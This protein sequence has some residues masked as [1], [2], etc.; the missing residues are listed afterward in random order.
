MRNDDQIISPRQILEK[1]QPNQ[2]AE[3]LL[4]R[5]L[6]NNSTK[7]YRQYSNTNPP[8]V[9]ASVMNTLYDMGIRHFMIDTPSVDKE[10]DEGILAA[11]HQFWNYP[12][13]P[14]KD[15]TITEL[16]YVPPS[17][18]DGFYMMNLQIASFENDASPS[19]P[20]LYKF[21]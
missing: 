20:T 14:R 21:I 9:E 10:L 3:A 5:T 19:K 4:I 1:F 7:K 18:S 8:Y 13:N 12:K 17:I 11:H 6:P 16:I 2:D 15:A